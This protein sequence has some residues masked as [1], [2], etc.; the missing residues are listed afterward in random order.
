MELIHKREIPNVERNP[1]KRRVRAKTSQ[2]S[3]GA[4]WEKEKDR[5][6]LVTDVTDWEEAVTAE[7]V[8]KRREEG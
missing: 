2:E 8:C 5:I 4:V 1:I 6:H 3:C 7:S